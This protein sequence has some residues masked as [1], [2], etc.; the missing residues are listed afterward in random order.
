MFL[1]PIES[2]T[3]A[4]GP[5]PA[6]VAAACPARLP[7]Q[8]SPLLVSR[9]RRRTASSRRRTLKSGACRGTRRGVCGA[10]AKCATYC[11]NPS[12]NTLFYERKVGEMRP[13]GKADAVPPVGSAA[14]ASGDT[15]RP[16]RRYWSRRLRGP[17]SLGRRAAAHKGSSSLQVLFVSGRLSEFGGDNHDCA[18]RPWGSG[19]WDLGVPVRPAKCFHGPLMAR[20]TTNARGALEAR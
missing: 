3:K 20:R 1:S 2:T 14:G 9:R 17:G 11:Q 13:R 19:V 6:R 7:L 10:D 8:E 12:G 15:W 16:R 5:G 4:E 18:R